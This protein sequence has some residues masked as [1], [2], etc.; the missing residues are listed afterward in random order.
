[1]RDRA[2]HIVLHD[3]GMNI[4]LFAQPV[5]ERA[6]RRVSLLPVRNNAA[7][8]YERRGPDDFPDDGVSGSAHVPRMSAGKG[9]SI[10][11][12]RQEPGARPPVSFAKE[13]VVAWDMS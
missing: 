11:S 9:A 12:N 7:V 5:E 1:M 10:R 13:C 6:R 4:E 8:Q 3:A 2:L